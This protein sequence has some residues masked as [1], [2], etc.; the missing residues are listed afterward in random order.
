M[1]AFNASLFIAESIDS[2][3]AQTYRNWELL[4]IDDGS[5]DATPAIVHSKAAQDRRIRYLHQENGRQAKARN[6]GLLHA[7]GE[8]VAFL[9]SD[10]LWLK[11]KLEIMVREFRAGDQDLLF[12]ESYIFEERF[13]PDG[14]QHPN[15]KRMGVIAR[16]YSGYDGLS[17]F[18]EIN[19]IPI[20]TVL[21]KTSILKN[22]LFNENAAPAEDYDLWLRMLIG[23]YKFRAITVPLAA[24][25]L[26]PCSATA[27]DRLA[28]DTV[29]A[30]I[31]ALRQSISDQTLR[32]LIDRKLR[33]WLR[34]KLR[35]VVD[36]GQLERFIDMLR[37]LHLAPNLWIAD[38]LNRMSNILFRMGKKVLGK[39]L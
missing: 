12:S 17:E 15:E 31:H 36:W 6:L 4:V 16:E 30:N 23:G 21:C 26:H 18:L 28:T 39:Q 24:Y 37:E 20:L 3:S 10:D 13:Q 9:D 33:G 19:R 8:L 1:P 34:R 11:D 14:E 2:V 5:T 27:G 25:R 22:L 29:I 38:V 32:E 7:R 35:M